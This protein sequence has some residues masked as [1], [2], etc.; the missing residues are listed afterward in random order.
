MIR[1]SRRMTLGARLSVSGLKRA[2]RTTESMSPIRVAVIP[3]PQGNA[4]R[5]G[6]A[7]SAPPDVAA[8]PLHGTIARVSKIGGRAHSLLLHRSNK[9]FRFCKG[10][11][12]HG[13]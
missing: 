5:S 7:A 9:R 13:P 11:T 12:R 8:V 2:R 1:R 3:I 6:N 10:R 4:P